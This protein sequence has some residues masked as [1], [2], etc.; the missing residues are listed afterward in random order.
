MADLALCVKSEI[1]EEKLPLYQLTCAPSRWGTSPSPSGCAPSPCGLGTCTPPTPGQTRWHLLIQEAMV[2][3][4]PERWA[5]TLR[6][7]LHSRETRRAVKWSSWTGSLETPAPTDGKSKIPACRTGKR[8]ES[9]R[10]AIFYVYD[11]LGT[12][13]RRD[14]RQ[15]RG[16]S[17]KVARIPFS[18]FWAPVAVV[19]LWFDISTMDQQIIFSNAGALLVIT[20]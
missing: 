8:L 11:S 18:M 13:G 15:K 7:P 5:G 6:Q 9:C 2:F 1:I 19:W 20:V 12:A 16:R 3:W 10:L 14:N 4:E 17:P